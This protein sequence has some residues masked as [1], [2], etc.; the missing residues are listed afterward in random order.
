MEKMRGAAKVHAIIADE[1]RE[2][3]ARAYKRARPYMAGALSRLRRAHRWF[4]TVVFN[5]S[6]A[7]FAV[8][9]GD[10]TR[11]TETPRA[12]GGLAACEDLAPLSEIERLTAADPL[13]QVLRCTP[14]PALVIEQYRHVQDKEWRFWMHRSLRDA[15]YYMRRDIYSRTVHGSHRPGYGK[16]IVGEDVAVV[17]EW[18]D[19]VEPLILR[20]LKSGPL[21]LDSLCEKMNALSGFHDGHYIWD[22]LYA[23][24][25]LQQQGALRRMNPMSSPEEARFALRAH[26]TGAQ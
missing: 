1:H 8:V 13:W 18:V 17:D 5:A 20:V 4:Q 14:Q 2:M 22:V 23:C 12:F 3:Q 16:R 10:G 24:E 11:P 15:R 26:L 21:D 9:F 19:P 25:Q 6:D 7:S